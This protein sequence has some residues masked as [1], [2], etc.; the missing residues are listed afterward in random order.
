MVRILIDGRF[1]HVVFQCYSVG[2][3][4]YNTDIWFSNASADVQLLS[5][6]VSRTFSVVKTY[7]LLSFVK[8]M[9]CFCSCLDKCK[10]HFSNLLRKFC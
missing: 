2:L 8:V 1:C 7:S 10:R 4:E 6:K 9:W 3:L 5:S